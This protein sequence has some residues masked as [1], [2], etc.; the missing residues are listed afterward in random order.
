MEEFNLTANERNIFGRRVKKIRKEGFVPAHLFGRNVKTRHISVNAKE[1]EEVYAKAGETGIINLN[2]SK[3]E[4]H[5]ALVKGIQIHPLTSQILHIDFYQVSMREKVKVEI[6]LETVGESPAVEKKV[7][8]LLT[9]VESLEVEALPKDLPECIKVDISK[10]ENVGDHVTV[11]DLILDREKI[12]ILA[13][14]S[15]V[16]ASIGE[17]VTKEAG[18]ILAEEEKEKEEAAEPSISEG[19]EEQPQEEKETSENNN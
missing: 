2:F 12:E 8:L 11:G 3:S 6:P 5:P 9:P 19:Q 4:S 15:L 1:F 18:E 17:F 13:D 16:V 10:L 14:P 7:G